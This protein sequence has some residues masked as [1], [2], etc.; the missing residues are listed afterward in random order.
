MVSRQ[1]EFKKCGWAEPR[2]AELC[3]PSELFHSQGPFGA[4]LTTSPLIIRVYFFL[5]FGFNNG[6]R[7]RVLLGNLKWA[8]EFL[9]TGSVIMSALVH[10]RKRRRP[11]LRGKRL[12][13]SMTWSQLPALAFRFQA[14][15]PTA[16]KPSEGNLEN[17][18]LTSLTAKNTTREI[19]VN[20][21]YLGVIYG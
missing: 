12:G 3:T 2:A 9:N 13:V 18:I 17:R 4:R 8:L 7:K 11:E 16:S 5:E 1:L 10:C 14:F 21:F 20:Q 6:T 15:R 19:T